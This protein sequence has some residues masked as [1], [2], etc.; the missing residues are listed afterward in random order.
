MNG[1]TC[2]DGV[3]NFTC[4]CPPNLTGV[5]CECLILDD[6]NLDCTYIRP[7]FPVTIIHESSTVPSTQTPEITTTEVPNLYTTEL[8]ANVTNETSFTTDT[9]VYSTT[10]TS[11]I[12]WTTTQIAWTSSWKSSEMTSPSTDYTSDPYSNATETIEMT[13][14]PTTT[15]EYETSSITTISAVEKSTTELFSLTSTYYSTISNATVQYES[16]SY[17]ASSTVPISTFFTEEPSFSTDMAGTSEVTTVGMDGVT[18]EKFPDCTKVENRCQN[19]G[20]C[21]FMAE[22]YRVRI[23]FFF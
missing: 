22:G 10:E 7:T 1:G 2:I 17:G 13:R 18:T 14:V 8:L 15:T 20:T 6:K 19:G 9:T 12:P 16:T 4:S 5:L 11:Y 21:T 3:D 23:I